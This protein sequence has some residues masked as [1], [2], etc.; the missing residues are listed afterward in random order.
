E[1]AFE[2]GNAFPEPLYNLRRG[3]YRNLSNYG[4][5]LLYFQSPLLGDYSVEATATGFG[6]REA[7]I[8]AGGRWTGLLYNH[9][10]IV[11]GDP[12]G[13][14]VRQAV[15][16]PLGDTS[17]YGFIRTRVDVRDQTAST[18]MNGRLIHEDSLRPLDSP[19]L[20]VRTNYRVQGGVDDLRI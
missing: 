7:H 3:S 14:L 10:Q 6:Y 18:W 17:K 15:S 12:R 2:H 13:E 1:R 8:V 20:G 11:L 19:W 4:D 9:Q 16:P 5:M